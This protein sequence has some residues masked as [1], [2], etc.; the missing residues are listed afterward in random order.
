M[1]LGMTMFFIGTWHKCHPLLIRQ[2]HHQN[3]PSSRAVSALP[4]SASSTQTPILGTPSLH[5]PPL[6]YLEP[7][8][9]EETFRV[10]QSDHACSILQVV[11][12]S[13][14]NNTLMEGDHEQLSLNPDPPTDDLIQHVMIK[15]LVMCIDTNMFTHL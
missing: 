7:Y 4:M 2:Q 13:E 12:K 11:I 8:E 15:N 10:M 3:S 5:H 9:T 6:P 1:P 14:E